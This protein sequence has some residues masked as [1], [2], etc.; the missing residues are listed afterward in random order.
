MSTEER[1]YD[2]AK[3]LFSYVREVRSCTP[4]NPSVSTTIT[5]TRPTPFIFT[6]TGWLVIQIPVVWLCTPVPTSK[7]S[8]EFRKARPNRLLL[9]VRVGP[10]AEMMAKGA[11]RFCRIPIPSSVSSSC[12]CECFG[13]RTSWMGF[14]SAGTSSLNASTTVEGTTTNARRSA[15]SGR[16]AEDDVQRL[17]RNM[18][19]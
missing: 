5:C 15:S 8:G 7:K 14:K 16:R 1:R 13:L 12:P 11:V 3:R 9:P 2:R 4:W 19:Y 17:L 6:T 18:V 10:T